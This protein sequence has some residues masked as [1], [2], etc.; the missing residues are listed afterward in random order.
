MQALRYGRSDIFL[1]FAFN[2]PGKS[3]HL[4][5]FWWCPVISSSNNLWTCLGKLP[6]VS[7]ICGGGCP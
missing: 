5:I 6:P 2:I 1:L 7:I 4:L 3:M